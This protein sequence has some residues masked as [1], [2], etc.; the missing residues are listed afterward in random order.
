VK[1]NL[2]IAR[3]NW[4]EGIEILIYIEVEEERERREK[5]GEKIDDDEENS[6]IFVALRLTLLDAIEEG[7]AEAVMHC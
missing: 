1:I 2:I 7:N 5:C 6:E 4:L 3:Y